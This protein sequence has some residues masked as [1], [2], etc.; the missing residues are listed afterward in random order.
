MWLL[1]ARFPTGAEGPGADATSLYAYVSVCEGAACRMDGCAMD[2][3]ADGRS[4]KTT[5]DFPPRGGGVT[6]TIDKRLNGI[7]GNMCVC[8]LQHF[9]LSFCL[10][11][12]KTRL[13]P[14]KQNSFG[15]V[16]RW[17]KEN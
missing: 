5:F 7:S 9:Y 4:R 15:L 2:G 1:N 8:V 6:R 13:F 11:G 12:G 3:L 10:N 17:K 14:S 16:N